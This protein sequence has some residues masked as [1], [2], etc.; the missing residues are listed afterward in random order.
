MGTGVSRGNRFWEGEV[1]TLCCVVHRRGG[2]SRRLSS[3]GMWV[4]DVY[5][6]GQVARIIDLEPNM[7]E[8]CQSQLV[9]FREHPS[10]R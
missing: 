6:W 4:P 5:R 10:I 2:G 7:K 9:A 3:G 1:G 8:K